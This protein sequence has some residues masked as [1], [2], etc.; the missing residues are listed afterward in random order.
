[1]DSNLEALTELEQKLVQTAQ[2]RRTTYL[3]RHQHLLG[4]LA[5]PM[6][7]LAFT[8][9][10]R[11]YQNWFGFGA[12]LAFMS[13]Y[14]SVTLNT[15]GKLA[16]ALRAGD[17][18]HI[19][20]PQPKPRPLLNRGIFGLFLYLCIFP[21]AG[22][23]VLLTEPFP[24]A[25]KAFLE[26]TLGTTVEFGFVLGLASLTMGC[27]VYFALREQRVGEAFWAFGAQL[28]CWLFIF[29]LVAAAI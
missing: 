4:W 28:V 7:L 5:I 24:V 20:L 25:S 26:E 15:I 16:G 18:M 17:S 12:L 8:P 13:W 19:Q 1:M 23:Y 10:L 14:R 22:C 6:I 29:V 3:I 21:F 11:R 9:Q 27:L 2:V